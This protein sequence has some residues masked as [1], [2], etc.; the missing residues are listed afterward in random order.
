ME[1]K[2]I[3]TSEQAKGEFDGGKIIEQNPL[4][5]L[6]KD[7]LSVDLVLYSTGHG[8]KQKEQVELANT[9]IKGLK[10]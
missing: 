10:F 8:G 5:F 9:L 3:H 6:V 2:I 1:V 7:L 4:G